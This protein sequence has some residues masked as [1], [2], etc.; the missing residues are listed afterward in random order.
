MLRAVRQLPAFGRK[1]AEKKPQKP[2]QKAA[3]DAS[4]KKKG[5][6]TPMDKLNELYMNCMEPKPVPVCVA[7]PTVDLFAPRSCICCSLLHSILLG[8]CLVQRAA[9]A[10]GE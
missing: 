4:A 2:A 1:V 7:C 10:R 8:T 9:D 6:G 3:V 5:P